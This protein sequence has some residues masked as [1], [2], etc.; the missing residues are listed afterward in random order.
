MSAIGVALR[1][2][3]NRAIDDWLSDYLTINA[4]VHTDIGNRYAGVSFIVVRYI[5]SLLVS[6]REV[7]K[8]GL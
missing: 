8:A 2:C 4:A 3:R 6:G 7:M 1:H 5:L